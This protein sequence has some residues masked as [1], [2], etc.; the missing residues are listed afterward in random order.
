MALLEDRT[1]VF[2]AMEDWWHF[3]G[4]PAMG[5]RREERVDLR[6]RERGERTKLRVTVREKIIK[7]L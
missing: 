1:W 7:N 6:R 3:V 4:G 2:V 5:E